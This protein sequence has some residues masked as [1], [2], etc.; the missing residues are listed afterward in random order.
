MALKQLRQHEFSTDWYYL[1]DMKHL[2]YILLLLLFI[3]N[4]AGAQHYKLVSYLDIKVDS[5]GHMQRNPYVI[6]LKNK[7]KQL[8]VIGTEHS[9]DTLSPMFKAIEDTFYHFKPQVIINEGGNL[10]KTYPSRN[11]A[12][13]KSG[14]LGLEKFLADKAGIKTLNGDEPDKLE[15]DELTAAY[16]KDEALLFFASERFI[17]PYAFGQYSGELEAVYDSVF[18]K[19][20]L[21]KEGVRLSPEE[22]KFS[23]YTKI[24]K[25][26]FHQDFSLDN[27]NQLYFT[28]FSR[29]HHFNDITRKSKELRD[30]Y[31]LK[32]IAETLKHHD[33][34]LVV[35]GGWH[36]LAIEPALKQVME[37]L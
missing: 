20:Y 2:G 10:Y 19:K 5:M 36:V 22:K 33:R 7:N 14:E 29:K 31:L 21:D 1:S 23:Y 13:N 30:Q 18:I 27:I 15:F 16:S 35:F 25:Q 37:E 32:Q 24:Y 17:F 26:Y 11:N 4:K 9:R 8:I 34:V 28:P 6:S 12:I 3:A